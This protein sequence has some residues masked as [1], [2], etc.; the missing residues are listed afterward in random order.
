[1]HPIRRT[2]HETRIEMMPMIDV[3]FL[4]LTFFIYAMALMIRAEMLPME[5]SY[6]SSRAYRKRMWNSIGTKY[7]FLGFEHIL[8]ILLQDPKF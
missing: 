5:M 7:L 3:I 4:L 2:E 6:D 1:M 8:L